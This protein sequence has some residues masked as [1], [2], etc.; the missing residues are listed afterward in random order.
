MIFNGIIQPIL[1]FIRNILESTWETLEPLAHMILGF[2]LPIIECLRSIRLIDVNT[3]G[4]RGKQQK[5][6][7]V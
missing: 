3:G 6:S 1:Q 7:I 4:A 2:C 5:E